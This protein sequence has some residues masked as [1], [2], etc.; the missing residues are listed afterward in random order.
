LPVHL[1]DEADANSLYDLLEKEVLPMYYDKPDAWLSIIK[2]GM[3]DIVP[4][5]DSKRLA[6]EYYEKLYLETN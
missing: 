3:R 1:Q 6:Q 5:F 2:K 4:Q